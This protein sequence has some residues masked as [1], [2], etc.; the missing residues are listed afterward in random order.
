MAVVEISIVPVGSPHTSLS[1]YVA[2]CLAVLKEAEG[3]TWQLTPMGTI[4]EGELDQVLIVV[5]CMHEQPFQKG[6]H[7]V[8]TTIRIDDRR[9]QVLTMTGKVA[10]VKARLDK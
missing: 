4:L 3:V 7:R 5:R 2:G 9:D 6:I 1:E 10:A 8:V